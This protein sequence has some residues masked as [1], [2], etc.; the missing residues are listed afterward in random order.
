MNNAAHNAKDDSCVTFSQHETRR[1]LRGKVGET[2]T[3]RGMIAYFEGSY[4][5]GL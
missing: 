1:D 5:N 2:I 3:I 4:V